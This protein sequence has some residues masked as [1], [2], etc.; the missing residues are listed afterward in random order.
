MQLAS[1]IDYSIGVDDLVEATDALRVGLWAP[2]MKWHVING[3]PRFGPNK[4]VDLRRILFF[5]VVSYYNV[6]K[7]YSL[8]RS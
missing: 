1:D 5:Q 7:P 3:F 2:A 4:H 8:L 6:S